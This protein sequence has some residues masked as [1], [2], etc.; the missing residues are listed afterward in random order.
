MRACGIARRPQVNGELGR[1]AGPAGGA[2]GLT[3]PSSDLGASRL[4]DKAQGLTEGGVYSH[5]GG[6]EQGRIGGLG[7]GGRR[8]SGIALVALTD[9]GQHV[10]QADSLALTAQLFPAPL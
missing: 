2:F 8:P 9:I 1:G 7:Q 4:T 5:F 3:L 10:T 6:I